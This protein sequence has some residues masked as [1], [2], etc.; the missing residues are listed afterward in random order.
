NGIKTEN[1]ILLSDRMHLVFKYH[2][3]I[4]S[5]Q[6]EAKGV[7]KVGT[8]KRGI[9]PTY[10]DKIRRSGIRLC[11]LLN[12]EKFKT[13]Y[14]ENLETFKKMYGELK[15][16]HK[17]EIAYHL[18]S[19]KKLKQ[20]IVNSAYYLNKMIKNGK[21][22]LIEGANGALLDVDHGTYPYVTSSNPSVGGVIT[23]T[24]IGAGKID[25]VIGI[26]KAYN[27]RVGAGPF[28]T[29]LQDGVGEQLRDK[30]GEFGSTTGRP[31]R[32]G[33]FDA[34]ASSYSV[35][36]NN[37]DSINLTKLD[38]LSGIDPLKIA[39]SYN[40]DEESTNKFPALADSLEKV[41][42]EYIELPGFTEDISKVRNF[43]DLPENA[44]NYVKKLEEV[45]KC[46]ISSI[47]VG[48]NR[49]DIIHI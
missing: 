2:K 7:N 8:T 26:M 40:I 23:G 32:C 34:V 49:E 15:Y 25:H 21:N 38:V 18:D 6:E 30:G 33:W 11:D 48:Q 39:V 12:P 41:K 27:T 29:E 36:I 43:E 4:D 13:K 1:R 44:K 37:F 16:E 14:Y 45:L 9:G 5:I 47:G 42:P 19:A 35:M 20:N 17:E 3:M 28:P 31:R 10:T 24:G 46:K 22:V